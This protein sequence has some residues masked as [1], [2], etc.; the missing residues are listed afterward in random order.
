MRN[1]LSTA[2]T[3][4]V[5]RPSA[6]PVSVQPS[7]V[8]SSHVVVPEIQFQLERAKSATAWKLV[9]AIKRENSDRERRTQIHRRFTA[10]GKR[11]GTKLQTDRVFDC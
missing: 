9:S 8:Y 1:V 11:P 4:S 2:C 10:K 7:D 3:A 5:S 6:A